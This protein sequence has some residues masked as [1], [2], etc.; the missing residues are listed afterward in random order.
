MATKGERWGRDRLAVWNGQIRTTTY[1]IDNNKNLLH[2]SGNYIQYL[3]TNYNVKE[4]GKEY[5]YSCV[6]VSRK[7]QWV[8]EYRDSS[9]SNLGL[10]ILTVLLPVRLGRCLILYRRYLWQNGE[11]VK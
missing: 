8:T 5:V 4:S 2:S 9:Q 11:I 3:V 6:C 7:Q 10:E 1:K